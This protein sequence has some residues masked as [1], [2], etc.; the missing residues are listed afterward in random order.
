MVVRVDGVCACWCLSSSLY[1]S[2]L[3]ELYMYCIYTC[4]TISPS[5]YLLPHHM[6]Q[7]TSDA[8]ENS[9]F[10][11]FSLFSSL[12]VSPSIS[13]SFSFLRNKTTKQHHTETDIERERDRRQK[14]RQEERRGERGIMRLNL[15]QHG[16]TH[17]V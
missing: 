5:Q 9:L 10:L 16:K 13:L 6:S 17:Q 2:L 1:L 4:M 3:M 15:L 7:H 8:R 14:E 12:S 11:S